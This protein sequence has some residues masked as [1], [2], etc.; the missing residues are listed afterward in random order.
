MVHAFVAW[1]VDYCNSVMASTPKALIDELQRG[2]NTVARILI[3]DTGYWERGLSQRLDDVL[4][5]LECTTAGEIPIPRH[6]LHFR[7]RKREP[8]YLTDTGYFQRK[9]RTAQSPS[10]SLS[11]L[12]VPFPLP[13]AI[14][15]LLRATVPPQTHRVFEG[16]V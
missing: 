10:P 15:P 8:T 5:W 14:P 7:L 3:S 16:E 12:S 13:S 6:R 4:H 11:S 9:F 1:R 2:S